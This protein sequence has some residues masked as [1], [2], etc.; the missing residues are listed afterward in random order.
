MHILHNSLCL[1]TPSWCILSASL[2][3]ANCLPI[4]NDLHF[5]WKRWE[6]HQSWESDHSSQ[7]WWQKCSQD[8][9][10]ASLRRV[11]DIFC[12]NSL[13]VQTKC[14]IS[15]LGCLFLGYLAGEK[16][17]CG[18]SV[19]VW[20]RE[21]HSCVWGFVNVPHKFSEIKNPISSLQGW[22]LVDCNHLHPCASSTISETWQS[23]FCDKTVH[24]SLTFIDSHCA[25]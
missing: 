17:W 13:A 18:D 25:L 15:C 22:A 10:P 8:W 5:Q 6:C 3:L 16:V 12:R 20:L 21:A 11:F 2:I 19:L 14:C 1:A 7:I 9:D 23:V 24:F 4:Q